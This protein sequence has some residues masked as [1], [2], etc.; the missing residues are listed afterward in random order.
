MSRELNPEFL[1]PIAP[2]NTWANI[3]SKIV[4]MGAQNKDR[5]RFNFHVLKPLQPMSMRTDP[6]GMLG[7]PTAQA[8]LI[9]WE[10][11]VQYVKAKCFDEAKN[12]PYEMTEEIIDQAYA[13][14]SFLRSR[15]N[16]SKEFMDW[17]LRI[18]DSEYE[19]TERLRYSNRDKLKCECGCTNLHTTKDTVICYDC[20]KMWKK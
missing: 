5:V 2:Y 11:D 13:C 17:L 3:W 20:A 8:E 4:E 6:S 1:L 7:S 14:L 12:L 18:V 15:T 10:F 16:H 19:K 9:D